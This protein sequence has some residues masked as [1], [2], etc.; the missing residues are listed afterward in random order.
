MKHYSP[1]EVNEIKREIRKGTP[2]SIIANELSN[3]WGRPMNG[4][5][6][7]IWKLSK[8]TRK[9]KSEYTGPKRK[10]YA[11]RAPTIPLIFLSFFARGLSSNLLS[12]IC[13]YPRRNSF[14][15][16][17]GKRPLLIMMAG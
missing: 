7:K 12:N 17:A 14:P 15:K 13:L 10:P 2:V 8:Q 1:N 3:K 9:I 5:Y 11:K 4:I 6:N 16:W